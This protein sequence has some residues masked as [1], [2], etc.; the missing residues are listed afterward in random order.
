MQQLL[1]SRGQVRREGI[2]G[3][4]GI[5][6]YERNEHEMVEKAEQV[7]SEVS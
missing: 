4:K 7:M 5:K 3:I 1:G 2:K 6:L